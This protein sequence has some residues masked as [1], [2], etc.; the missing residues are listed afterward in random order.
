MANEVTIYSNMLIK[1]GNLYYK[2]YPSS[3]RTNLL[4]QKGPSPGEVNLLANIVTSV[5]LSALNNPGV[6]RIQNL[7]DAAGL[8]TY[9]DVGM[10]DTL[11]G[12]FLPMLEVLVGDSWVVRLSRNLGEVDSVPAPTG[13][14]VFTRGNLAML[15]LN[16][17]VN[18]LVEAFDMD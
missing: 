14:S 18:V 8:S 1:L 9:I 12:I 5:N 13:T 15:S 3:F 2:S 16:Y 4:T 10:Y 7:G 11:N 17:N 6:C